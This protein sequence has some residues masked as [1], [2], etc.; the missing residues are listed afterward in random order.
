M[1]SMLT[2]ALLASTMFYAASAKADAPNVVVSIKPLHSL[3]TAVMEG[4]GEPKLIVDGAASPH[5]FN[6]RP[7]NA[8]DLQG[9][10]IIFWLG[11]DFESFLEKPLSTLGGNAVYIK[12]SDTPNLTKLEM[13]EGGAFEAHDH[14]HG[15]EHE[16]EDEHADNKGVHDHS[17]DDDAHDHAHDHDETD[18]HLW[19]DPKNAIEMTKH[20]ARILA[21]H[22]AVNAEAYNKNADAYVAQ[23]EELTSAINEELKDVK[24]KPFIVFHDAYQYYEN[25][26]GL[27]AAG[28]ITINPEN[29]PGA[30]RIEEL[31][32]KVKEAGVSC[33]FAEPQ[34]EPKV[35]QVIAEGVDVKT[36]TLDP[37]AT[38]L[39]PSKT[40]YL[41]TLKNITTS[42]KACLS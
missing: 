5:S 2:A 16:H 20:I 27:K 42:F 26:F 30:E 18:L 23:I 11:N 37:E 15:E 7:S 34:F 12:L 38:T 41:D 31:R 9:A 28:S 13:R 21:A 3:V 17:H 19:L 24:D 32:E 4:V 10:N 39:E 1:K 22:D 36:E 25:A 33:I 40:L 35:I 14:S 8:K 29:A 6:L